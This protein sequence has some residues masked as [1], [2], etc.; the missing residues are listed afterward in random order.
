MNKYLININ[1]D[2]FKLSKIK[3]KLFNF[4]LFKKFRIKNKLYIIINI[5]S[6]FD[7]K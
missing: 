2:D 4:Y 3:F 5:M 6:I 7:Y 1:Y